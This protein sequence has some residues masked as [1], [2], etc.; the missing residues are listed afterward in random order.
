MFGVLF[1]R[2]SGRCRQHAG[3]VPAEVPPAITWLSMHL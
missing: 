2:F 3:G 1:L